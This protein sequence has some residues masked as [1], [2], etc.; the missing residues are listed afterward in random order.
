MIPNLIGYMNEQVGYLMTDLAKQLIQVRKVLKWSQ[1]K[2]ATQ[3]GVSISTIARWESGK[4]N[5]GNLASD[6]IEQFIK[7]NKK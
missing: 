7:K 5:P 1:Q 2:L 6:K 3:L 4:S